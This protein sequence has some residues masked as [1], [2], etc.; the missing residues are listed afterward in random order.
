MGVGVG[1][2][3][4][5]VGKTVE[6][7]GGSA[8]AEGWEQSAWRRRGRTPNPHTPCHLT[9]PPGRLDAPDNTPDS[10]NNLPF[11]GFN[12]EQLACVWREWRLVLVCFFLLFRFFRLVCFFQLAAEPACLVRAA[13]CA[14][15]P[16]P[17]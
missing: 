4:G 16:P 7:V 8:E 15:C 5:W 17:R 2:V 13:L 10:T 14:A 3:G 1:I 9:L 6:R 11:W 12:F